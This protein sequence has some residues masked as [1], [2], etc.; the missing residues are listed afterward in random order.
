[1]DPKAQL[2][3]LLLNLDYSDLHD[4]AYHLKAE[5][6]NADCLAQ[7]DVGDVAEALLDTARKI[8]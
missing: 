3:E 2:A 1:M 5:L 4:F 6:R 7:L 8:A